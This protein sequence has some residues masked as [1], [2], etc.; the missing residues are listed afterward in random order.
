MPAVM[1][2]SY[3]LYGFLRPFL[4]RAWRRE[5]EEDEDEPLDLQRP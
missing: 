4:S 1:F 5:L 3:L 2:V